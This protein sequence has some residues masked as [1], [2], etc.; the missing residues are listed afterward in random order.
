MAVEIADIRAGLATN[1]ATV[2]GSRQVSAYP[3]SAPTP[4][5]LIVVGFDEIT[6]LTFSRLS[7]DITMNVQGLAGKPTLKSAYIQLDKW[8]S[9]QGSL[10]VWHAIESDPTLGGKVENVVVTGCDGSQIIDVAGAEML[11]STWHV[12]ITL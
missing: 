5:S 3:S 9:P 2:G 4:P 8:L 10:N 6:P 11:G 1:L 7:Y 12:E